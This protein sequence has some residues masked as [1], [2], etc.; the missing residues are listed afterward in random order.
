MTWD[1]F[2][3]RLQATLVTVLRSPEMRET[4]R[5]QFFEPYTSTSE[6]FTK[7]IRADGAKWAKIVKGSGARVD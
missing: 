6:E 2:R 3:D 4:I 7:L 1:E 5:G